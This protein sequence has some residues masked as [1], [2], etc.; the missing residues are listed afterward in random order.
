MFLY[1]EIARRRPWPAF[2]DA[3]LSQVKELSGTRIGRPAIPEV[4]PRFATSRSWRRAPSKGSPTSEYR[5]D[6][7][8]HTLPILSAGPSFVFAQPPLEGC[9]DAEK[10]QVCSSPVAEIRARLQSW[11][12]AG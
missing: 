1:V 5:S 10:R 2:R 8:F 11:K 6:L 9:P 4:S 7:P 3:L 12:K